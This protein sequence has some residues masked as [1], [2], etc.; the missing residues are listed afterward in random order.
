MSRGKMNKKSNLMFYFVL[1]FFIGAIS[2]ILNS[3]IPFAA[4][5]QNWKNYDI[6][7]LLDTLNI[8]LGFLAL[9][10]VVVYFILRAAR[11]IEGNWL[12]QVLRNIEEEDQIED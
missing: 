6:E 4:V 5:I 9:G 12:E 10:S 7:T 3:D 8:G 2:T 11:G 1:I